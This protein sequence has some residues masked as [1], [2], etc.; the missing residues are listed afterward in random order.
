MAEYTSVEP[1]VRSGAPAWVTGYG[2]N[3][4]HLVQVLAG[5]RGNVNSHTAWCGASLQET[6]LAPYEQR[7]KSCVAALEKFTRLAIEPIP[8]RVVETVT[9]RVIRPVGQSGT[10][11]S[12]VGRVVARRQD[13]T[14]VRIDSETAP[15]WQPPQE[16]QASQ[17][18]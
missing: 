10:L 4:A 2:T 3:R 16:E 8:E 12:L 1:T 13:W 18:A 15:A 14:D 5:E 7:C 17:D 6:E 11:E 9:V